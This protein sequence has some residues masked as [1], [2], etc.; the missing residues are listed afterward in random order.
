MRNRGIEIYIPPDLPV[1]PLLDP[2]TVPSACSEAAQ[3]TGMTDAAAHLEHSG[4]LA[5]G[6]DLE[7]MLAAEGV[8]GTA[9]PRAMAAAHLSVAR[10][11]AEY[12]RWEA[13]VMQSLLSGTLLPLQ[14]NSGMTLHTAQAVQ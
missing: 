9:L 3:G 14:Q 2:A 8:P 11:A 6:G 10:A 13:A 7:R 4:A 5:V 12:H 1:S